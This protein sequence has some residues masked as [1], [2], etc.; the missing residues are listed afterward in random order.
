MWIFLN[1]KVGL[2]NEFGHD[3]FRFIHRTFQEY[4]AAKSI[5]YSNGIERSEDMIYENIKNKIDIPNWRVPLSMTFGIL[6][7]S[8]QHNGLFNNIITRLLTNEQASSN[9][10]F[11]TL[12]VPFVIIDSLND[13]YFSSKDTEYELIRKLADMLLF[14]YKNMSGFS[15]LKEHQELIHSYF[16]KL[17]KKYDNTIVK[18]FIE[19]INHEENI[20]PC[21]NI[22]YQLKWY[23][24][25]FHEIFLKNLHNDS[26]IWNWPIDSVLRFY[27]NEIEDEA[28]LTQLK[29][30]SAINKNPEMIQYIIKNSDWLCLITALYGGYK[31][32]NTQTTISE[33][34]EIAQFLGL[35][36]NERAPFIF[37]YQEIWG[38]DD[39]AYR[40]AVHLDTIVPKDHWN[41]K[42]IFD[43][44]EIYKESFLTTKI[45]ELLIEEKSTTVLIEELRK[46][47]NTQK[48]STSEK[49]E[50]LIALIALG[51]F[52]FINV[53]IKEG[54]ETFIKS[55]G[56]E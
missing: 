23:N 41:E 11:S 56:N 25:K 40:M 3:S 17:K 37:Y 46:Q 38:R 21:A 35:S 16:L 1:I 33:Y 5:I 6:S 18:W 49:T 51:D 28:V 39:P 13:M 29:F 54:E 36:D 14:D 32:Y 10:Q 43:K 44:N 19:K 47:I 50:A 7:K 12:L 53:I 20:A 45:L 9:T 27:S 2:L 8:H 22:I 24:P 31:N 26:V 48:L 4:L 15:R 42:P 30:K 34:Y 52:D 55:F